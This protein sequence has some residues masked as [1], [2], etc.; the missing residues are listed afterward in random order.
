MSHPAEGVISAMDDGGPHYMV[1][2]LVRQDGKKNTRTILRDPEVPE[3]PSG[4]EY[5]HTPSKHGFVQSFVAR[6]PSRPMSM[7]EAI[8]KCILSM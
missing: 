3:A 7:R 8:W 4:S 5:S 6:T 2:C 1:P